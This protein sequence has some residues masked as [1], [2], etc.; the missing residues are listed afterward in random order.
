MDAFLIFLAIAAGVIGWF[1]LSVWWADRKRRKAMRRLAERMGYSFSPRCDEP[2]QKRLVTLPVFSTSRDLE[3][4]NL[5]R[6]ERRGVSVMLFDFTPRGRSR[7]DDARERRS[8]VVLESPGWCFPTFL[9]RRE[10]VIDRLTST[11]GRGD[12]DFESHEFSR[13]YHVTCDDKRF[14]YDVMTA[15][16]MEF[17]LARDKVIPD[18]IVIEIGGPAV[19][20][21]LVRSALPGDLKRLHGIAWRF[22]ENIP[23]HVLENKGGRGHA[24]PP[25]EV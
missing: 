9:L 7:R 5:V 17:L 23:E 12:I 14:A 24:P 20:F 2:L 4:R 11:V 16:Q 6:G 18:D 8:A 13:K 25:P 21:H 10:G 1:L 15:R 19:A 3:F 22:V